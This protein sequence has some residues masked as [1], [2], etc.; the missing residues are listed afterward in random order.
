MTAARFV[1]SNNRLLRGRIAQLTIRCGQH[2]LQVF[3]LGIL[4]SVFAQILLTS[5]RD[6]IVMQL[7]I[8]FA[9]ILLMMESPDSSPGTRLTTQCILTPPPWNRRLSIS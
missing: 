3:C 6:D 7:A 1:G 5:F 8:S 9:G 2:S 4:L